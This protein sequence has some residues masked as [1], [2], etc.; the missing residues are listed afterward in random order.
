MALKQAREAYA[1][2]EAAKLHKPKVADK[3]AAA[4]AHEEALVAEAEAEAE[5]EQSLQVSLESRTL[6][7]H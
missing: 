3:M 6:S 7:C 2:V 1:A 4:K 5:A